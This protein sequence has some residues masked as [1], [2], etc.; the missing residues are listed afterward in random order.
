MVVSLREIIIFTVTDGVFQ[1]SYLP[2]DVTDEEGV[3]SPPISG[4]AIIVD[5]RNKYASALELEIGQFGHIFI[6]GH[7]D[8]KVRLWSSEGYIGTL[9]DYR[10]EVVAMTKCFQGI[11]ICTWRGFIH[12][13]DSQL[14]QCTKTIELSNLPFK[15]LSNNI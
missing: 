12:L 2:F 7:K 10:D 5:D 13:W 6:T 9:T 15:I 8:G 11:A 4:L 1:Q 14:T 3:I